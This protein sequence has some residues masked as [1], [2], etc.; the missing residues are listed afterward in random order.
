M[1]GR[2]GRCSQ[3]TKNAGPRRPSHPALASPRC[4]ACHSLAR[5]ALSRSLLAPTGGPSTQAPHSKQFWTLRSRKGPPAG[6]AGSPYE[7]VAPNRLFSYPCNPWL[8][9]RSA[10]RFH[11][12]PP[13]AYNLHIRSL[14]VVL[15]PTYPIG[16]PPTAPS[17]PKRRRVN[18]SSKGTQIEL[19]AIKLL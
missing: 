4:W 5:R 10:E 16:P 12:P 9:E 7:G 15:D 11:S 2:T 19:M 18:T 14:G 1:S 13:R 3:K 6:T 17:P 8:T